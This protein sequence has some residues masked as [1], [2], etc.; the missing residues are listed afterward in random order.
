M[1]GYKEF[2]EAL[3][4]RESGN[5]Y[6]IENSF[7]FL[8]RWQ[9]GKP[10]LYDAGLSIDNYSPKGLNKRRLL[11]KKDF[12]ANKGN[13]QD[14]IMIWHVYNLADSCKRKYSTVLGKEI[15]GV[16]ISLSGLVAGAH[17]KGIGGVNQFL[18]G[19]DNSDALGTKI[20]E[21]IKKF[22]GYELFPKPDLKNFIA[23]IDALAIPKPL[24]NIS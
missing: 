9:F 15:N 12:L 7:G 19:N 23:E 18:K 17:L 6:S 4:A 20:S 2:V 13:I 22:G 3:G 10:R 8:G 21:Y 24:E 16:V 11:S 1:K 5:D 14:N